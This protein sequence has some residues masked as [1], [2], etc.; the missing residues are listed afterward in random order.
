MTSPLRPWQLRAPAIAR[1]PFVV[2]FTFSEAV[3]GFTVE[4]IVGDNATASDFSGSGASYTARITPPAQGAYTVSVAAGAA[5]D[6]V[7]Y[8]SGAVT[9]SGQYDSIAPTL[10]LTVPEK[11]N[12]AFTATFTFSESVGETFA[13]SDV[14]VEN[15]TASNL[16]GSGARLHGDHHSDGFGSGARSRSRPGWSRMQPVTATAP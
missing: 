5:A 8:T 15:G 16:N 7:G 13:A 2:T 10:A 11:V 14:V 1:A 6:A 12:A 4:D 9:A 3:S